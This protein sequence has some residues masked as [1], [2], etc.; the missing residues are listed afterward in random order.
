MASLAEDFPDLLDT[1]DGP[2]LS[3]YQPTHRSHPDN[4]QDPIRF[5][6][7]IKAL[8]ESLQRTHPDRETRPLLEPFHALA[9][10]DAFWNRTLDGLAVL[11]APDFFRVYRLQR[12][13]PE[14]VVV[15]DSFHLKPLLRMLQS[16]DRYRVLGLSRHEAK[17]YEGNRDVLDE[18]EWLAG[19]PRT[20]S[21]AD[22]E[23]RDAERAMRHYGKSG[24]SK[25]TRHGTDVRQDAID[26]EAERFFRAV[27]RGVLEEYGGRDSAPLLLAALPENHHLF[28][29]VSR[30]PALA[31]AA[32]YAHPDSI[33][34][35][36]LRARAWELVQP[37]YVERLSGLVGAFEAARA[38]HLASG[39]LADIGSAVVAGRVATLL[40]DADRVVPGSLDTATG[41]VSFGELGAPDT[42]DLLDD[43]AEAVLRQGGEVVV[44]PPERMPVRSGAAA[45]YRY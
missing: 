39:D 15:A 36:E 10:D 9:A 26:R 40:I 42:D 7:G 28:R 14:R 18:V 21:D 38:R 32:L 3:L 35:D 19:V 33:S 4:Q 30:N 8:E 23:E 31:S 22:V 16:A 2:C 6:N 5:R 41:A 45:T 20:P 29:R 43:L 34:L 13:V 37:Y 24:S 11:G 27:D 1:R 44:V 17:L 25:I 12:S